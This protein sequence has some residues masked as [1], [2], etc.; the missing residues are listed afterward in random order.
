MSAWYSISDAVPQQLNLSNI[1]CSI[2]IAVFVSRHEESFPFFSMVREEGK[3]KPDVA[4]INGDRK[5]SSV[6]T[7]PFFH[8][9]RDLDLVSDQP[10]YALQILHSGIEQNQEDLRIYPHRTLLL[11]IWLPVDPR[12]RERERERTSGYLIVWKGCCSNQIIHRNNQWIVIVFKNWCHIYFVAWT[13]SIIWR[14]PFSK[15]SHIVYLRAPLPP[16]LTTT[17]TSTSSRGKMNSHTPMP[18]HQAP[19]LLC[20]LF[21]L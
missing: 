19:C 17:T 5:S 1:S 7:W 21:V 2:F 11:H 10:Q 15:Q 13:I 8:F 3:C 14:G 9:T 20:Q 16:W 6:L 18:L 12:E 4:C